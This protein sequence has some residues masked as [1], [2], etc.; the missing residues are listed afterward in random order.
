MSCNDN[1]RRVTWKIIGRGRVGWHADGVTADGNKV[2][3]SGGSL[4]GY[5]A[6]SGEGVLVYDAKE[7]NDGDFVAMV[8][9]GPICDPTLKEGEVHKFGDK[10]A[11]ARMLPGLGGAFATIGVMALLE[12]GDNRIGSMDFVAP[13]LYMAMLKS[14][15]KG[16]KL[17]KT[18]DKHQV[19]WE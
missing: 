8:Y 1:C 5:L 9:A 16:I 7:A 6:E 17:G 15:V 11:L 14:K 2:S 3:G 4:E 10:V 13:D 12:D 19:V 18:N